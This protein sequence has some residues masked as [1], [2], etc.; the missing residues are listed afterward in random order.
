MNGARLETSDDELYGV[1]M[2]VARGDLAAEQLA[3]WFRQ[4]ILEEG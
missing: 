3:I 4:R 1:T 2:A